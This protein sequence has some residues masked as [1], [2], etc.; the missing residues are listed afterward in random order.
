MF[1]GRGTCAHL[2]MVSIFA[3]M[4]RKG[5]FCDVSQQVSFDV[6]GQ[7]KEHWTPEEGVRGK[8]LSFFTQRAIW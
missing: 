5:Y 8:G 6:V 3:R 4:T 1:K 7:L 2:A